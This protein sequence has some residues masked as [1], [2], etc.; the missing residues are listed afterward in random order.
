MRFALFLL[1]NAMLFI[2]PAELSPA[3]LGLPIYEVCILACLAAA[4]PAVVDVFS[5]RR[6]LEKPLNLCV[7]AML[8]A[9]VLSS[10]SVGEADAAFEHGVEF[11]KILLYYGLLV[12]VTDSPKRLKALLAWT[13]VFALFVT[14]LAVLHY[15]HVITLESIRFVETSFDGSG[16]VE[17]NVARLGSTGLFQDPNDMCLM[18]GMAMVACLY[19]AVEL[20]RW[21]W[22]APLA[23]FGYALMLTH[24]RGGFLAMVAAL[25]TLLA[26]RL[27]RRAVPVALVALPLVFFVFGGRQTNFSSALG[28]EGTGATRVQLWADGLTLFVRR[29]FLGIGTDHYAPEMGHV[30]HNS[31]IHCYVELGLVGGS[32]FL[33]AFYLAFWPLVRLGGRGVSREALGDDL[34]RLRPYVMAI[35]V[36]YATG[37]F[38]LSCPYTIP[39]YT[40]LG[41]ASVY[42]TLAE[43]ALG[44]P[45]AR[46]NPKLVFRLSWLSLFFI[47][48]AYLVVCVVIRRAA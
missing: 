8:P 43:R 21:Y 17:S 18:L 3:L 36:G 42:L 37:L 25:G 1:V 4:Y 46:I 14:T 29:P 30:A 19:Q 15:H 40:V 13:A 35:V 6:L 45:V 7:V 32:V 39:T 5:P 16:Q 9:I 27:G 11:A 24:S 38:S 44:V 34:S 48:T 33:S 47:T 41:I 20:R 12:G 26:A 22:A 28:S 31:F 23:F 10:L 2:R